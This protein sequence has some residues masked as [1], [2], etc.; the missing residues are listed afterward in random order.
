MREYPYKAALASEPVTPCPN[1]PKSVPNITITSSSTPQAHGHGLQS[2][3]VHLGDDDLSFV[4]LLQRKKSPQ[5][6]AVLHRSG[7]GRP[8]HHASGGMK[9][10][11]EGPLLRMPSS[12]SSRHS[13]KSPISAMSTDTLVKIEAQVHANQPSQ[14]DKSHGQLHFHRLSEPKSDGPP[15]I[16]PERPLPALPKEASI[17]LS[18]SS[19]ERSRGPSRKPTD[20]ADRRS[21]I[22]TI[23]TIGFTEPDDFISRNS[24]AAQRPIRVGLNSTNTLSSKII[25]SA[26]VSSA[27]SL[28]SDSSSS[29]TRSYARRSISGPRAEKVK[30]KRLRDL[31]SSRSDTSET[32]SSKQPVS[33]QQQTSPE[34]LQNPN[35]AH[36]LEPQPSIDQLDQFPGVP[37]SRPASLISPGLSRGN[38]RAQHHHAKHSVHQRQLS[39]SSSNYFPAGR[40]RQLLSQ[41]NIFIVVDSDPVTTRFRAGAMSP[42]PS[43]GSIHSCSGSPH[44]QKKH[45]RRPS[46]L[47]ETTTIQGSPSKN[48]MNRVS[49]YSLKSQVSA[50]GRSSQAGVKKNKR[51]IRSIHRDLSTSSD[52]SH[53]LIAPSVSNSSKHNVN[54]GKKRRRWN[55]NDI[56][57]VKTLEEA[58][59]YYR[60]T[61]M[62][63]EERLRDQADQI[64]MM[65]RV[66]APMNRAR[67][68]KVPSGLPVLMDYSTTEESR[69]PSRRNT[70]RR[71]S[72]VKGTKASQISLGSPVDK[73]A[74]LRSKGSHKRSDSTDGNSSASASASANNT[75]A[76]KVSADD[77]SMTDP[78]E[79]EQN[80]AVGTIKP[81][82]LAKSTV[83]RPR[84]GDTTKLGSRPPT[85]E[86]PTSQGNASGNNVALHQPPPVA[87]IIPR[88]KLPEEM[89]LLSCSTQDRDHLDLSNGHTQ[90]RHTLSK[91]SGFKY[92]SLNQ[93]AQDR[94]L[95]RTH[96]H[97]GG[98]KPARLRIE[99]DDV[100]DSGFENQRD[101][102]RLSVNHVLTSTDQMDRA[103]EQFNG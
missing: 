55:S 18:R 9:L 69:Q 61:I 36:A 35:V 32:Q 54:R 67:G 47:K 68:V 21:S 66:I 60:S 25:S 3:V 27:A 97:R 10:S 88:G 4:T 34:H 58:L 51:P 99:G 98:G 2:S 43:I 83:D 46:N 59:D 19:G 1:S 41:S 64:Q 71:S 11:P 93:I 70:N 39:K 28:K 13:L 89:S 94:H 78:L 75:D 50:S 38:S 5:S 40:P 44:R 57:H 16:P 100:F 12:A 33:E 79:Y 95:S 15:S 72:G 6:P 82:K 7:S 26:D 103:I 31:A 14:P 77:A 74:H 85:Q 87:E 63:Q 56:G 76:T 24:L 23:R 42:A 62:M 81:L 29:S 49:L 8:D 22:S 52:E 96:D 73:M 84:T 30:E 48:L 92:R 86:K 91:D 65:I 102:T 101:V 45:V 20:Q 37:E 53:D 80:P 17:E 90:H